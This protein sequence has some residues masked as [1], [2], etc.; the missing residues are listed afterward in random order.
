M[1]ETTA[2]KNDKQEM[3]AHVTSCC[4][5]NQ[6]TT[7]IRCFFEKN[8]YSPGEDAKMYCVVDNKEGKSTVENVSVTLKNQITYVSREN[9]QKTR[10][11]NIFKNVFPGLEPGQEG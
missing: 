4:C 8:A 7:R 3:E 11:I 5:K 9:H 10:T 6:G 1:R 2:I